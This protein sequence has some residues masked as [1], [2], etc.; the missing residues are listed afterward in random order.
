[1]SKPSFA[2]SVVAIFLCIGFAHS[3][4]AEQPRSLPQAHAHND[5][6][7][8]RPLLDALDHRFCSVEADIWLAG[9]SSLLVGHD[10]LQLRPERTLAKLYLEPLLKRCQANDGWVHGPGQ[11]LILLIDLKSDGNRTYPVLAAELRKFRELFVS[12][13]GESPAVLAILSGS[14]PTALVAADKG[15]LCGIDGRLGDLPSKATLA[16]M[17]LVSDNFKNHFRWRGEDPMPAAEQTKLRNYVEAV[18]AEGRLLRFWATPD[19]PDVWAEL[20]KAGVDLI[21]TD[22]LGQLEHFLDARSKSN[23]R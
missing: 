8:K 17:P 12:K 18:H 10:L 11:T 21:G 2:L 20:Q 23:T 7:H 5:Y 4:F 14:R 16:L 22:D 1:M 15:R 13:P 19:T 3:A 9:E 6:E